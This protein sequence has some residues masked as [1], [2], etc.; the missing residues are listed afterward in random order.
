MPII[1]ASIAEVST[2]SEQSRL[3]KVGAVKD[4]RRQ[5]AAAD[6]RRRNCGA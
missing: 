1:Q 2:S 5:G 6:V 3:L 4:S